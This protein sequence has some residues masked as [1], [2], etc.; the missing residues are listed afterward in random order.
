MP[1]ELLL[2]D[3][4]GRA[5]RSAATTVAAAA[6]TPGSQA[7]GPTAG[8]HQV[9]RCEP[10]WCRMPMV[11]VGQA[12]FPVLASGTTA[13][14]RERRDRQGRDG[15][16][17]HGRLSLDP[18]RLS[19]RYVFRYEDIAKLRSYESVLR[20]DLTAAMT[21]A[22]DDQIIN[23]D[24]SAP[25]VNG[26]LERADRTGGPWHGDHVERSPQG[27]HRRGGW[28]QRLHALRSALRDRQGE[29]SATSRRCSAPEHRTTGR[30][31]P[32]RNTSCPGSAAA[33]CRRAAS[34]RPASNIQTRHH[35]QD[36]LPR[37]ERRGADLAGAGI[38]PRS[39]HAGEPGR[40]RVD[41]DHALELQDRP[42]E[43]AG[44]CSRRA[45]RDGAGPMDDTGTPAGNLAVRARGSS[46]EAS[47]LQRRVR[48]PTT[49]R[50]SFCYAYRV[51]QSAKRGSGPALSRWQLGNALYESPIRNCRQGRSGS[52]RG[53][54]SAGASSSCREL[55]CPITSTCL[56]GHGRSSWRCGRLL[57]K[58]RGSVR[59]TSDGRPRRAPVRGD[60]A[61]KEP[62]VLDRR[63][64][65][66]PSQLRDSFRGV[67]PGFRSSAH[68]IA[69]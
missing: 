27:A 36:E 47:S 6:R 5:R 68:E 44:R 38:D 66:V 55:A 61:R 40:G 32:L 23:G 50:P 24:G 4:S 28:H 34:R 58:L 13:E 25:N 19:A 22:M 21:D 62:A 37:P 53:R 20:R 1:F 26:F 49:A 65:Y 52:G 15:G 54:R 57:R 42:R 67:S 46:R 39:V 14:Q 11:E 29:R 16:D 17:L 56:R 43:P 18:V 60:V 69:K 2:P 31:H 59:C 35:R 3:G 9:D 48:S 10:R 41:G 63:H 12:N 51:Q 7:S 30:A 8:V 64:A 45:R 33:W